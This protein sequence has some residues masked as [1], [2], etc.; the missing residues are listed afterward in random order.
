MK[1]IF[2]TDPHLRESKPSSRID[3]FYNTQFTK[4]NQIWDIKKSINA[5]H[6]LCGGDLF[7]CASSI[8]NSFSFLNDCINNFTE[9]VY[10][11]IGT[12]DILGRN[13]KELYNSA[14]G[15]FDLIKKVEIIHDDIYLDNN[16][17]VIRA[18]PYSDTYD[19]SKY[20]FGKKFK[21]AFKIVITHNTILPGTVEV[22]YPVT[23]AS[24]IKTDAN[25][26]LC[27]HIHKMW[28]YKNKISNT[29]FINPGALVRQAID[30]QFNEPSLCIFTVSKGLLNDFDIIPL[31]YNKDVFDAQATLKKHDVD[32]NSFV[33]SLEKFK[34]LDLDG[35]IRQMASQHKLPTDILDMIV[36]K[37]QWAKENV[38]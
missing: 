27:G 26:V 6:I 24:E 4:I 37:I 33:D 7:D 10:T 14:L 1:F 3:D 16:S 38:K 25:L 5:D 31:K 34:S 19:E 32:Y 15:T 9:H 23:F 21:N 17:I 2:F 35:Y 12:H 11:V 13:I 22:P 36:E 18:V 20:V 28:V 8:K 30:E 29:Q